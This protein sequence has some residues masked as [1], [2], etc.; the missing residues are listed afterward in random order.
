MLI[1]AILLQPFAENAIIHGFKELKRKPK[2]DIYFSC[3]EEILTCFIV[4][5]GN[6]RDQAR[7]NKAQVGQLHK[8]AALE[9]TQERLSLLNEN[10]VENGFEIIDLEENGNATGTKVVL[11]MK[12]NEKF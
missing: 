7:R 10:E 2:I 8:S 1:P 3:K 4:D 12:L 9:V 6:G 11:R 5:N